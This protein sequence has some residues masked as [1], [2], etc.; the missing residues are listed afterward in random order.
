M[1]TPAPDMGAKYCDEWLS[2]CLSVCLSVCPLAYL[3]NHTSTLHRILVGRYLWLWLVPAM[4][5]LGYVVWCRQSVKLSTVGGRSFPD[6]VISVP[7]LST[8]RQRFCPGPRS[9][10]LG[11]TRPLRSGS[12][13]WWTS[14][15]VRLRDKSVLL[16]MESLLR[17]LFL[18]IYHKTGST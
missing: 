15:S 4:A 16:P 2:F 8:F 1:T 14:L 10:T 5:A 17:R 9:L 12:G 13:P 18:T 11:Q 6:N 7:S 3:R